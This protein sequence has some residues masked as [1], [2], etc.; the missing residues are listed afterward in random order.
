[1]MPKSLRVQLTLSYCL[2]LSL[3]LGLLGGGLFI[4]LRSSMYAA[5]DDDLRLRLEG[6][7]RLMEREIPKLSGQDLTDEFREHSGL[8]PGGDMLSVWDAKGGLVFQSASIRDYHI[9][10]PAIGA[11]SHHTTI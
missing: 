4:V 7:R 1:M 3:T 9:A 2:L 5:V 11:A 8:R 6:V 10:M